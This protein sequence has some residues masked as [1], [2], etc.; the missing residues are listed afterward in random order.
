MLPARKQASGAAERSER[1]TAMVKTCHAGS[2][3]EAIRHGDVWQ[4]KQRHMRRGSIQVARRGRK[5]KERFVTR[6]VNHV[7]KAARNCI[8]PGGRPRPTVGSGHER[9]FCFAFPV[10]SGRC[11]AVRGLVHATKQAAASENY[12]GKARLDHTDAFSCECGEHVAC[13]P[14]DAFSASRVSPSW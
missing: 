8:W 4:A 10:D 13:R 9:I 6:Q 7:R 12:G 5:S 14:Q 2:A 11:R 3:D 1:E